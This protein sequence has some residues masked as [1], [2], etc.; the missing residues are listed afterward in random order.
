VGIHVSA[1]KKLPRH[2]ESIR[3]YKAATRGK[4]GAALDELFVS[5]VSQIRDNS[6]RDGQQSCIS[7]TQVFHEM[8]LVV[9]PIWQAQFPSKIE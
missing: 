5:N 1:N 2:E 4:V 6:R 7:F 3:L 9:L 8:L